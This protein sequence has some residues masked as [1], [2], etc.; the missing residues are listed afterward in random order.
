[1]MYKTSALAKGWSRELAL[2][3]GE[4]VV[5]P[6]QQSVHC[7]KC[8]RGVDVNGLERIPLD[9][10]YLWGAVQVHMTCK[11]LDLRCRQC[12]GVRWRRT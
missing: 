6:T 4:V 10:A 11:T 12:R 8:W 1:M 5:T 3:R 9:T 2:K 7:P